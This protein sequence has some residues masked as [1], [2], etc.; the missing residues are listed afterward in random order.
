[1][2]QEYQNSN[3][4]LSTHDL[5]LASAAALFY[6]LESIDRNNPHKALFLFKKSKDLEDFVEAYWRGEIKVNPVA[7][8]QQIKLIKTRLYERR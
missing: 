3:D 8:F 2:K 6:P 7:Y 4:Y 5:G 1:M